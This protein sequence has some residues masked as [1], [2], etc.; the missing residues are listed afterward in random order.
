M[1]RTFFSEICQNY[2]YQYCRYCALRSQVIK[3]MAEGG[4][5]YD[6]V[7]FCTNH[8]RVERRVPVDW[9]HDQASEEKTEMFYDAVTYTVN[10]KKLRRSDENFQRRQ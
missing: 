1:Y 10:H 7:T 2:F 8:K 6:E 5:F 3:D 9:E 4:Y